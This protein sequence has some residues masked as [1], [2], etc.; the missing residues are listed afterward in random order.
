MKAY[1]VEIFDERWPGCGFL[2]ADRCLFSNAVEAKKYIT[3]AKRKRKD[4]PFRVELWKIST[5][6]LAFERLA[7]LVITEDIWNYLIHR[8]ERLMEYKR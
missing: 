7:E 5:R 4:K 2:L 6:R 1:L 8:E 3:T